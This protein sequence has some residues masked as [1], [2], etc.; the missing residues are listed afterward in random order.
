MCHELCS[1]L[2]IQQRIKQMNILAL[3]ARRQVISNI[4]PYTYLHIEACIY[5]IYISN[6][7][8]IDFLLPW[9]RFTWLPVMI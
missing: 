7:Y 8:V 3:K 6:I 9:V 1:M 5:L 4:F 2:E